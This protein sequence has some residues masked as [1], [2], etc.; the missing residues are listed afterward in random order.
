MPPTREYSVSKG[1]LT[2]AL[3]YGGIAMC[4]LHVYR[5][6]EEET[7]LLQLQLA[8]LASVA[9]VDVLLARRLTLRRQHSDG[10]GR[11]DAVDATETHTLTTSCVLHSF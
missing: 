2:I 9:A 5:R 1:S 11:D 4:L 7:L 10:R 8:G 3:E 6:K